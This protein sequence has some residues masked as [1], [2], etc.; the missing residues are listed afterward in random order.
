M[1]ALF[2]NRCDEVR[3]TLS[4]PG[5]AD[6]AA[7]AAAEHVAAC[8]ECAAWAARDAA[9]TR[10]WEAT[11]P[12]EPSAAVWGAFWARLG[13]RTAAAVEPEPVPVPDVVPMPAWPRGRLG[14][15]L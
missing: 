10:L 13:A 9:L 3:R 7:D 2:P 4:A 5:A 1:S 12:V 14:V 11:R 8:P 15:R 6:L